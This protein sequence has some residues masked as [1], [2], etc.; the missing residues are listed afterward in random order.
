MTTASS[1]QTNARTGEQPGDAAHDQLLEVAVTNLGVIEQLSLVFGRGMT[2]ITG[3]TGAGKTLVLT[4]LDLL[5]GGRAETSMVGPHGDEAVVEGRFLRNGEELVLRRVVPRAGRSRAY[6]DGRLATAATLAEHGGALIELH[7]QHG[8]T[9]LVRTAA[10]RDALDQHAG[11]DLE[12]LREAQAAERSLCEQRD[13]LGGDQ[14]ERLRELELLRFQADEIDRAGVVDA[15][16]DDR[17]RETELVLADATGHL[18]VAHAVAT[19][20]GADGPVA[21]ALAE[22]LVAVEGRQPFTEWSARLADLDATVADLAAE[23]RSFVDNVEADPEQLAEL[24]ERRRVLSDLRRRFGDTLA[25]VLAYR[26]DLGERIAQLEH[27]DQLAAEI[28]DR[29][30]EAQAH[31]ARL[32]RS[33]GRARRKAA[34]GLAGQVLQHLREL[35]L[36]DAQFEIEVGADPG[37]QVAISVSMNRGTPLQPLARIA[38][39]G[40]LARTMLA[41]RLVLSAAPGTMVFDEVDAGIGGSVAH[42]L[43][44]A[45]GRLG[46]ERQV[47]VVTHLAQV[48]AFADQQVRVEKVQ[49]P[50]MVQVSAATLDSAER[51]IELSRMLSGQPDSQRAREHAAELL[52]EADQCLTRGAGSPVAVAA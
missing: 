21:N 48:A 52:E 43:G 17:L 13:T 9:A 39:G 51:V 38:S 5:M 6:V 3:E 33:V 26:A 24:Q 25:D 32:G 31:T 14:R 8:H 34:P 18:D 10:Q 12:P 4:A 35:A 7:G 46:R 29:I 49:G 11:I 44:A 28:D 40:E 15:A 41:L 47:L 50:E 42:S 23:A 22:A 36:P 20:L 1:T 45:L 30:L 19:G 16:E 37:D 27:H 2:A